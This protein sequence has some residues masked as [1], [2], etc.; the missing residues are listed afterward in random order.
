MRQKFEESIELPE[1]VTSHFNKGIFVCSKG[2]V[3]LERTIRIPETSIHI[4]DGKIM[5]KAPRAT[6]QTIATIRSSIA[7][8]Q[9]LFKGLVEPFV[10]HMEI[11]NV[12]FP[13]TVKVEGNK[14][15]VSNF[16]G[17]KEKR[18]AIIL[19]HVTVKVEGNKVIVSSPNRESAGQTAANIERA[20]RIVGRDR[21]IFQDGIFITAKPGEETA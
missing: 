21:R 4:H 19:P 10:Y 9:N 18:E 3:T 17:E 7:H 15:S 12:H 16:L 20:T 6:R 13:M 1:G 5:F 14:L 2:S 11:C 8:I